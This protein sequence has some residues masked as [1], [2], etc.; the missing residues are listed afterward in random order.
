VLVSKVHHLLLDAGRF[1]IENHC[2]DAHQVST[3]EFLV[4]ELTEEVSARLTKCFTATSLAVIVRE[5]VNP[6]KQ[7]IRHRDADHTH[8]PI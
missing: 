3:F 6:I 4:L 7:L 8:L 5:L 1:V 2:N